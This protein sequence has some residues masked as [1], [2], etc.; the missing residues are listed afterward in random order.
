YVLG[1]TQNVTSTGGIVAG[2]VTWNS[3]G[4]V[5]GGSGV[6]LTAKGLTGVKAGSST[7]SIDNLGNAFFSGTVTVLGGT[8]TGSLVVSTS[9]SISSGQTAYNTGVGYWLEYNSG[10]PRVSIGNPSGN[11]LNWDGS[12]LLLN[13]PALQLTASTATFS[14]ALSAA[15]GTFAGSLSAATGT[16]SGNVSTSGSV[17]AYG[18]YS[19]GY[20]NAAIYGQGTSTSV[21]VLGVQTTDVTENAG[22]FSSASTTTACL[23]C[24]G[25]SP[26]LKVVGTMQITST[27]LITNLNAQIWGNF[28]NTNTFTATAGTLAGYFEITYGTS[29]YKVPYY[30]P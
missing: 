18:S 28:V 9:G 30:N 25:G 27:T 14:G 11:Y 5:T 17:F 15:S 21:G 24:S 26:A 13:S 2:D 3:S 1:G 19:G 8:L 12:N 29:T 23:E 7:F 6:A 10:T 4:T 16:F 22:Y 20:G